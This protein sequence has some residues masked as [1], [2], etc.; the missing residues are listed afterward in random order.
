M[1]VPGRS[2]SLIAALRRHAALLFGS[3]AFFWA[4]LLSVSACAQ[5][6]PAQATLPSG[7]FDYWLLALSWS[8][9]F[10][11]S[12]PSNSQCKLPLGFVVHGLWPQYERSHPAYCGPRQSVPADLAKRMLPLMPGSDL[13]NAQWRKHGTCSGLPMEDYFQSVE[14]IWRKL[15]IPAP[16]QQ[17]E[18]M[19][20]TN[21]RAFKAAW[22]QANP[23]FKPDRLVMQCNGRY[24]REVRLCL[25][26][27]F[28]A[29]ACGSDVVDACSANT[30]YLRPTRE[31][32]RNSR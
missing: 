30:I 13:I 9:Q 17:P 1:V 31:N 7:E 11:R 12:N 27:D 4:S 14:R 8:P 20:K 28:N 3:A 15:L 6:L 2:K 5:S 19:L 21:V 23:Q 25:D 18:Q 24:L 29:R 32:I 22:R 26:K 16:Y 10:C